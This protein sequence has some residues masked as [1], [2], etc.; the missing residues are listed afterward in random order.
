[1]VDNALGVVA[2]PLVTAIRARLPMSSQEMA[3]DFDAFNKA[4]CGGN[5]GEQPNPE[6]HCVS[7]GTTCFWCFR[8]VLAAAEGAAFERGRLTA[9]ADAE[10]ERHRVAKQAIK[11]WV[12][13]NKRW[14]ALDAK[15]AK[16]KR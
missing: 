15:Q 1:M 11:G 14:Y 3:G 10:E 8:G 16:A 4:C 2:E 12:A 13:A 5:P 9:L 7:A 6:E